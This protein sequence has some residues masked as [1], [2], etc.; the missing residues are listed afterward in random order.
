[1]NCWE[2]R[3]CDDGVM[4]DCPAYPEQGADCWKVTG[5][6]CNSGKLRMKSR[7][8]KIEYCRSCDFYIKYAN[9]F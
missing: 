5:T 9:R 2:F 1:M 8:E 4:K 7:A 6:L 3:K